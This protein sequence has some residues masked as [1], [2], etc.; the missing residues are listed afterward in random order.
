MSETR[1]AYHAGEPPSD[2]TPEERARAMVK[3]WHNGDLERRRLEQ[4]LIAAAICAAVEAERT[5]AERAE[6]K[7]HEAEQAREAA[8]GEIQ[9]LQDAL[10]VAR[11]EAIQQRER[12]ERAETTIR[13]LQTDI[14]N[15][16]ETLHEIA[17]L[18]MFVEDQP[19][20]S[21]SVVR[22]AYVEARH[23]IAREHAGDVREARDEQ[24]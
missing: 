5:R 1:P 12:A 16:R 21:P 20:F 17:C 6:H 4:R 9:I 23:A 22:D 19:G 11:A 10:T 13:R 8:Y 14:Q 24:R 15:H 2:L 18:L 7:R 3:E